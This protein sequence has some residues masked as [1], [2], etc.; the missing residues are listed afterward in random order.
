MGEGIGR[1]PEPVCA[2]STVVLDSTPSPQATDRTKRRWPSSV[3][4]YRA[5]LTEQAHTRSLAG[6]EL[7]RPIRLTSPSL[8]LARLGALS[9]TVDSRW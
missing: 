1:A 2:S 4:L 5:S 8:P 9:S 7:G 6:S 3:P